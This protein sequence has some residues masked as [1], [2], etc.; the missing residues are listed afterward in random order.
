MKTLVKKMGSLKLL[1][2]E[3]IFGIVFSS[4]AMIGIPVSI[5]CVAPDLLREPLA[6]G[7]AFGVMLF[8]GLVGMVFLFIL[9]VYISNSLKYSWSTTTNFFI[10]TAK[11]KRR[12]PLLKLPT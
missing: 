11:R 5:F 9:I 2:V 1:K 12:F 10:Y 7:I 4:I 3:F 6:W 8:F